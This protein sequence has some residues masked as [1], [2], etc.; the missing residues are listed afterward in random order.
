MT[1]Y[2][3]GFM[4][5]CAEYGLS[6]GQ[7][8]ELLKTASKVSSVKGGLSKLRKVLSEYWGNLS[9]K[10]ARM[11]KAD[12]MAAGANLDAAHKRWKNYSDLFV[13][14]NAEA[15]DL[16]D[17]MYNK[18]T[19]ATLLDGTKLTPLTPKENISPELTDALKKVRSRIDAIKKHMTRVGKEGD[20]A[21]EAWQ[22]AG[23]RYA[24]AKGARY[25]TRLN[26]ALAAGGTTGVGGLAYLVGSK[27]KQ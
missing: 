14:R 27:K 1:R 9:G 8:I 15:S 20:E 3:V 12:Y 11:A 17:K 19:T 21:F 13:R 6:I 26:T 5:K 25:A 16:L 10:K 18:G 23:G 24:D 4:S 7:S 22:R 2:E